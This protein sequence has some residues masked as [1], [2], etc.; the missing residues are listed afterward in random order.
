[1]TRPSPVR[2]S[3]MLLPE[4]IISG[5]VAQ[6][7]RLADENYE[8]DTIPSYAAIITPL[9]CLALSLFAYEFVIFR[10]YAQLP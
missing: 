2:T 7:M 1:M 6:H 10:S 3:S 4:L 8:G 5:D 9:G